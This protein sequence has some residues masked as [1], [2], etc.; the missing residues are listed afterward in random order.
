MNADEEFGR[1]LLI[2]HLENQGNSGFC[3]DI[4][5]N[6]PPDLIVTWKDGFQW[7]VEV[8]RCYQQVAISSRSN[9]MSSAGI[10]EPLRRFGEEIGERTK[11]IRRRDYT[12]SLGPDPIDSLSGQPSNFDRAWRKKVELQILRHITSG[13]NDILR[14]RGLWFKPGSLGTRWTVMV[15]G[16]VAEMESATSSMLQRALGDKEISLP[17]WKGSFSRRWLLLLNSYPLV[18]DVD[19]I[20]RTLWQIAEALPGDC[21]FDGVYWSGCVDRALIPILLR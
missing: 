1:R 18:N 14:D 17:N 15:S 7:G 21:R 11:N 3:Y 19:E 16:G 12:I 10:T 20:K 2:D 6:D 13:N 9:A 8:T 4:N 5:P